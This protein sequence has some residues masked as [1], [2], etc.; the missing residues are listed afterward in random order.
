L[1]GSVLVYAILRSRATIGLVAHI[2]RQQDEKQMRKA[3]ILEMIREKGSVKNNAIETALGVS[4]ATATN[5]LQELEG[6][7]KIEQIGER[8]RFVSYKLKS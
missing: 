8:G 6:E 2:E 5:Y 7:G 3:K 1:I 4:D